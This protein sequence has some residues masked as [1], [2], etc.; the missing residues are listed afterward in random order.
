MLQYDQVVSLFVSGRTENGLI[1]C[2]D[3]LSDENLFP[4]YRI[5]VLALLAI[6]TNDANEKEVS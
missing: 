5:K 3:L 4:Y 1:A 6:T 2:R